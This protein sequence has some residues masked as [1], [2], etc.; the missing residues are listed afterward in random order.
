MDLQKVFEV[1]I[2]KIRKSLDVKDFPHI[3]NKGKWETTFDG[4]WTGGFWIGL[5]WLAYERNKEESFKK[6]A[7]LWLNRLETRKRSITFDLGFLFYPSFV[8]GY[9]LTS[10][11]KLKEV[12]LEAS[13]TLLKTYDERFGFIYEEI[14]EEKKRIGR[15]I[16]DIMLNLPL[17]WWAFEETKNKKYYNPTYT[18]SKNT[19]KELIRD[20][21]STIQG[22]NYDFEKL[23]IL[24]KRTF[25]GINVNSCWSRGQAWGLYGYILAYN[26]TKDNEFLKVAENLAQYFIFNLPSD[27]IPYWDFNAPDT[28]TK[29]R[30]SSAAAIASS[31]LFDL[32]IHTKK[33]LYKDS[34][35]KIIKSLFENYLTNKNEYGIL[36]EGC[37]HKNK[38]LGLK[39]SLIWG[40]YYFFE[41][42]LKLY[43]ISE[44]RP[45]SINFFNLN[46]KK[47]K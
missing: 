6:Q 45:T 4:F 24:E 23:E 8:L 31:G 44:G 41:G 40:D 13:N 46:E 11:P 15:V 27:Y 3:T 42:L 34:A 17:L 26:Y 25:Q 30:D 47:I 28:N 5:L 33:D 19:I 38:N 9:K 32:Y 20:D 22:F 39:E 12:A 37:F 2:E 14:I 36:T 21:Y 7:Y 18:H 43:E 1:I 10:D 29:L 35:I 16:I